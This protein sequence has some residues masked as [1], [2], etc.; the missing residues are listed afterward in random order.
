M[1]KF[2]KENGGGQEVSHCR[3]G[4]QPHLEEIREGESEQ[5]LENET[6]NKEDCY[7]PISEAERPLKVLPAPPPND[8]AWFV[9]QSSNPPP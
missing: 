5:S 7:S 8:N 4:L 2:R 3:L 6:L 1:K 9:K